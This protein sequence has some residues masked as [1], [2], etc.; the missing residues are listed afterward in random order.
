MKIGANY[1]KNGTC[2]F[3]VWAPFAGNIS[4]KLMSPSERLIPMQKNASGYWKTIAGGVKPGDLYMYRI[5]GERDRPDPVSY[6]QPD[7]V[8]RASEVFNHQSFQWQDHEWKGILLPDMIMYELHV[9]AFT[10]EG[11][12]EAIIG[13]LDDL[14]EIGINAVEIMPVAQFPGERNWGYDGVFPFAVQN[15][16]GGPDG[17]KRLVNECHGKGVAVI[18]DVVFN[19]MGPEGNYLR[20]YGPYFTDRY[21]TPW[22]D[23][24]NFDGP[25][26][27]E[28]RRFFIEN[29]L[30][31]FENYHIDALRIDAVHGIFDMSAKHFVR[32]LVETV[33]K[34]SLD[35]GRKEFLIAE[36]D[37]N[38]IRI[39]QN[40]ERGGYGLDGHWCDDFH[41]SLHTL[42]TE[43]TTGYYIDFGDTGHLTKSFREGFVYSGQYSKFRK[44]NHGQPSVNVPSGKFVV[45]SQNHDQTGNRMKGERL[46]ALVSF[47]S[48]KLAAGLVLLS[49]YIPLL[50][51]GE[52]YGE[53]APFLYFISHSDPD[54]ID[55][56]RRGRKKEFD[57]FNW[58]EEP[59]DPFDIDTFLKSKLNWNLRNQGKHRVL[60]DFYKEVICMRK[61]F[62]AL[63]NLDNKCLESRE[64]KDRK[65]IL[66]RRW[67]ETSMILAL[68]NLDKKDAGFNLSDYEM[69]WNKVLDSS[70]KKWGGRGAV[71]PEK[72]APN[73][74]LVIRAESMALYNAEHQF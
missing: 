40:G 62:P 46:S 4:L 59:P 38:D 19:H 9:G 14:R 39:I 60:F 49:P 51:M 2:E 57:S 33:E 36:S 63:A 6:H 50:F 41:H 12:F 54:L 69:K 58:E 42:L 1:S 32:E 74:E 21:K 52:E 37:L 25:H 31:W 67:T 61:E 23:A 43:E 72:I 7:G 35:K 64:A 24:I 20:D 16:Y 13:R 34:Y 18:L 66:V 10:E 45:F 44:R 28:V 30:Y 53:T 56:V 29:A 65:F 11:T 68:F 17:L 15:S 71:L 26:S 47:E 8:H 3:S 27:N 5:E 48:L 73:E 55:G 70:D 22:G